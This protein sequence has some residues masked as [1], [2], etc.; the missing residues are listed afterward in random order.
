V[1]SDIPADKFGVAQARVDQFLDALRRE[2][3]RLPPDA[4]SALTYQPDAEQS[5]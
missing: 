1:K 3:E 2:T 5:E 4:D